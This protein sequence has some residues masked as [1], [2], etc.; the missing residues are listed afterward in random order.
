MENNERVAIAL[1]NLAKKIEEMIEFQRTSIPI[2]LVYPL[3]LAMF[4][5]FA[6]GA[7]VKALYQ[8]LGPILPLIANTSTDTATTVARPHPSPGSIDTATLSVSGSNHQ[9]R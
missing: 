8:Y 4:L 5:S 9:S 2:K 6:G 1:E 3:M 7:G